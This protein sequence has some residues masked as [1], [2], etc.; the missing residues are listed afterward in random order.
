MTVDPFF[1][2]FHGY[3]E[4]KT[5]RE[6]CK[7]S[8]CDFFKDRTFWSEIVYQTT[9]RIAVT[10]TY[11]SFLWGSREFFLHIHFFFC[12]LEG[13]TESYFNTKVKHKWD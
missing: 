2:L 6:M 12:I 8:R 13:N 1:L 3:I 11:A 7:S 9:G 10:Y 4:E 5:A